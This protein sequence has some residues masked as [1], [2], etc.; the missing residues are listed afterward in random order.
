MDLVGVRIGHS[1]HAAVDGAATAGG[2]GMAN[3]D[4]QAGDHGVMCGMA[5]QSATR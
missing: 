4:G 5:Q 3:G 2:D 1:H